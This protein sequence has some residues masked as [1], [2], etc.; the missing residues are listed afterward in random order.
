MDVE[1]LLSILAASVSVI[2][3]FIT[4]LMKMK[5]SRGFELEEIEVIAAPLP[6][7][8]V[9][10]IETELPHKIKTALQ[11]ADREQLLTKGEMQIN[12]E[13]TFPTDDAVVLV[14]RLASEVAFETYKEIVLPN[15]KTDYKVL[16]KR[17]TVSPSTK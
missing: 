15:L 8:T 13:K 3:V 12:I 10:S 14:F 6:P 5:W 9:A 7:D 4:F 11:T 2:A 1:I 17:R 16:Q